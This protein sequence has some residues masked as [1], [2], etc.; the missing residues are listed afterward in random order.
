MALHHPE[1]VADFMEQQDWVWKSLAISHCIQK[2]TFVAIQ[3]KGGRG[4]REMAKQVEAWGTI[5][6]NGVWSQR[7][8]LWRELTLKVVL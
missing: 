8:A 1:S 7:L 2:K 4:T 5:P 3:Q 6:G